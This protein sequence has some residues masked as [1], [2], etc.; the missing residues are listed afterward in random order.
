MSEHVVVSNDGAV[1]VIRMN[2]PEKKNALTQP[3]YAA[4]THALNEAQSDATIRCIMLAGSPGAFC[5]G[6]DIGDFQK[7]AEG[8]L[9]PITV[10]FLN[11]LARNQKPLVA[12]VG[13]IAI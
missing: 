1:R 12:T 9:A 6:S 5:A 7:R 10:D 2:R 11:A 8:G 13:G 3:M 4:M